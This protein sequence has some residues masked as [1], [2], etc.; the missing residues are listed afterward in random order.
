MEVII[1]IGGLAGLVWGMVLLARGGLM[2][3]CLAVLLAGACFGHP[4]YH[5]AAGPLPVTLDRVLWAAVLGLYVVWRRHGRTE[6]RPPGRVEWVLAAFFA[7]LLASTMMHDWRRDDNAPLAHF[8]FLFVMPLGV[9]VVARD[10]CMSARNTKVVLWGLVGFAF[11]LAVIGVAEVN[12]Q[13]WAV[14]PKYIAESKY[15]EFL[16]RARGPFLNPAASG[17]YM[18][19]GLFAAMLL[20]PGLGRRGRAALLLVGLVLGAGLYSTL[21]RTVWIG[22]ALGI[23][24]I[25]ALR[26][27]RRLRVP[28]L[29]GAMLL[30]LVVVGTQW[31]RLL[32]YKRDKGLSAQEAALSVQLR[33]ILAQVAWNMF[34]DRPLFGCGFGQYPVAQLDYLADRST[35]LPLGKAKDYAQH[36]VFLALLT[37]TGLVGMALFVA[38]LGLWCRAAWRV[39]RSD[40]PPDWAR[41][42]G[43]LFLAMMGFYLVNG[44]FHDVSLIPQANML[45]FFLAGTTMATAMQ[46]RPASIASPIRA[47][48]I[49][50][51]SLAGS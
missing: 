44:M 33:P 15:Q 23:M 37:E 9:Y 30:G 35:T 31:E 13:W 34:L 7:V 32:V 3:G 24:I 49:G 45:L 40:G 18:A 2:A 11:Y 4:F 27:P 47:E 46:F 50:S 38:V 5:V 22:A 21:T 28:L 41:A 6:G 26:I 39:W 17:Y 29:G 48:A 43:L 51:R 20:W 16:G 14:F 8:L 10:C 1:F 25:A 19:V 36:N 42:Q 12:A